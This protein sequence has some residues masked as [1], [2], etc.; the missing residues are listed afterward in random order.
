M[1]KISLYAITAFLF[2]NSVPAQLE[3]KTTPTSITKIEI[4]NTSSVEA[5][6]YLTRLDEIN[7][8]EKSTL[9]PRQKKSLRNEVKAIKQRLQTL[10][11]G[12]YIS[13]G[14]IIIILLLIIILF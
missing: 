4:H 11:G 5:N 13:V 3:A 14:A 2:L 6:T 9:S 8:M 12:I 1:K 10:D 7:A